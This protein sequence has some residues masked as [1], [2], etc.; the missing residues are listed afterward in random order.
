MDSSI[1]LILPTRHRPNAPPVDLN[2]IAKTRRLSPL[3]FPS[4]RIKYR[5]MATQP[6]IIA[7][8][9]YSRR[10]FLKRTGVG[11]AGLAALAAATTGSLMANRSGREKLPG[12]GSIFEPRRQDLLR[13]W[14]RRLGRFRLR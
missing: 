3:H 12:S 11:V 1:T 8:M 4:I 9:L 7:P 10:T 14:K 13:H 5:M 2:K 6:A